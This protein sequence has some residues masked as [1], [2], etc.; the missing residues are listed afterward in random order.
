MTEARQLPNDA[1]HDTLLAAELFARDPL[2]LGGMVIRAHAGPVR[3]AYLD[4][5]KSRLA[6]R[7]SRR[8]PLSIQDERLLGGLDLAATLSAG[9][10]VLAKGLLAE[11]D[12]GVLIVPM[13]ERL[14]AALSARLASVM[15]RGQIVLAREGLTAEIPAAFGLLL[16]DESAA[17][18]ERVSDDLLDRLAFHVD[19]R[20]VSYQALQEGIA[21]FQDQAAAIRLAIQEPDEISDEITQA[22]C[23]TAM[24][25]GIDS[26]RA[27]IFARRAAEL[28]GRL[29]GHRCTE[30]DDAELAA[31]LVLSP[32]ATIIPEMESEQSDSDSPP[33]AP[34]EDDSSSESEDNS[35]P[36]DETAA[37][38]DVVLESARA[39]IPS[40]LLA[41]LMSAQRPSGRGGGSG[42]SGSL[43]KSSLRG[44]PIGSRPGLVRHGARLSILDTL[45]A[46]APWQRLRAVTPLGHAVV[47]HVLPGHRPEQKKLRIHPD[48]F[49]IR[50]FKERTETTTIFVVDASGSSAMH[51]LAEA[52][53]AVELL[54][55]DCYVR[56]DQVAVIAFRHQQA[57]VILPPTRSLV[58]A[59][60]SLSGLPGGG[61]TPLAAAIELSRQLAESIRRKGDTP[62][63]VMLTDGKANIS[64]EG[65]PGREQAR[66]DATQAARN[67]ALAELSAMVIDTSPQPSDAARVLSLE[68]RARY[69]PLPHAGAAQ[70]SQAVKAIV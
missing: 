11:I 5:I 19:L 53:G 66:L 24:A 8:L 63:V 58:R 6:P 69:L 65:K 55:A 21:F 60:R 26:I 57:E 59:K 32:R 17:E 15:D 29:M 64:R 14:S 37:L 7:V 44:R 50:R 18:D 1:L 10:P 2:Q 27:M 13:A 46:A 54:L 3:S 22:L 9:R 39:A 30:R 23:A 36:P 56:R 41:Q 67:F 31:R 40:G 28:S 49:R 61:G 51:R 33:P 38:D 34:Q 25:L 16:L 48:D 12:G 62:V 42:K 45:R 43:K 47:R 70:V 35:S 20:E 68:M 4:F 52:K